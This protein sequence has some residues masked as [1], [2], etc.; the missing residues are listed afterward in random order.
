MRAILILPLLLAACAAP[1]QPPVDRPPEGTP[2]IVIAAGTS[3]W[4][5]SATEVY[6]TDL[7]VTITS[8][9]I[10][11]DPRESA[12][13]VPGAYARVAAVLRRDGPAAVR[14]TGRNVE[15]C[16]GSQDVVSARP[17]V[18]RFEV[19][20]APCGG[21]DGPFRALFGAALGAIAPPG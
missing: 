4:G 8:D 20:N 19:L 7:V 16:P 9:G 21:D 10:G 3:E 12:Q 15:I 6:G 14:A 13:V 17:P 1:A 18:G 11:Q 2:V 5:Y